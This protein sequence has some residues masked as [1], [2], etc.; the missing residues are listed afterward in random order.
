MGRPPKR[1]R[2]DQITYS[3]SSQELNGVNATDFLRVLEGNPDPI[4]AVDASTR[5][6]SL[7]ENSIQNQVNFEAA[8]VLTSAPTFEYDVL[9]TSDKWELKDLGYSNVD[10]SLLFQPSESVSTASSLRLNTPQ[11]TA[12][13]SCLSYL[14]LCLSSI[15]TL[16]SFPISPQTLSTLYSAARTAKSVIHC[17]ICPQAFNTSMQNLMLL[18]TLLN[19]VADAW[20]LVSSKDPETVGSQCVDLS[21]IALLPTDHEL[22]RKHWKGWLRSVVKSAVVGSTM[23]PIAH[24]AQP[25]CT[26][27]PSL[28]SLIEEMEERQRKRHAEV[29]TEQHAADPRVADALVT[30][31]QSLYENKCDEQDY[32]CLRVVGTARTVIAKFNFDQDN[33]YIPN[34]KNGEI[35]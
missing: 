14:Y 22:R 31:T 26:E 25:R 34:G 3:T 19:V 1:R 15:S 17:P 2:T 16:F 6:P 8:S 12:P 30:A 11:A 13:C 35:V 23:P 21:Y 27:T 9:A 24:A 5:I 18:G 29:R 28:L 33:F 20:L 10:S 7:S 4:G 32:F